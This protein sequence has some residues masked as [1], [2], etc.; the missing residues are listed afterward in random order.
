VLAVDVRRRLAIV[1]GDRDNR[2]RVAPVRLRV[3]RLEAQLEALAEG[4]APALPGTQDDRSVASHTASIPCGTLWGAMSDWIVIGL[5]YA[6]ACGFFRLL[7]GL[8]AAEDALRNW[9]ERSSATRRRRVAS[10]SS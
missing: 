9:G 6:F 7:G 5:A 8:G 10:S 4:D 2:D 3:V 1:C